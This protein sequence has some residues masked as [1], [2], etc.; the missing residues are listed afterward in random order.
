MN[1][2]TNLKRQSSNSI[3]HLVKIV[4][5]EVVEEELER[6]YRGQMKS[7]LD[8]WQQMQELGETFMGN[9]QSSLEKAGKPWNTTEDLLLQQEIRTALAQIAKNHQRSVGA[10]KARIKQEGLI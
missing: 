5:K 4:A 9:V 7:D 8:I 6:R 3:T 10:I 2:K 1:Y